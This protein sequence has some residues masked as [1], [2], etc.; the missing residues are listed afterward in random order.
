M[1]EHD[2]PPRSPEA[3]LAD[4]VATLRARYSPTKV[5][6]CRVCGGELSIQSV[7]GGEPTVWA[8]SDLEAD[9]AQ[10][11]HLRRKPGRTVADSHYSQSRWVDYRQGGDSVVMELLDLLAADAAPLADAERSSTATAGD[12]T[13]HFLTHITANQAQNLLDSFGGEA[14]TYALIRCGKGECGL[15]DDGSASPAGLYVYDMNCPE[16]GVIYL[17]DEDENSTPTRLVLVQQDSGVARIAAERQ[18]QMTAEGYTPD[19]DD[20][21][22][23]DELLLAA[24]TY[25]GTACNHD[26][27]EIEKRMFAAGIWPWDA[28]FFKPQN[29]VRDLERAGALVAAELD[30]MKRAE[31]TRG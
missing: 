16:E 8:C 15:E 1:N 12:P 23:Q 30:R 13:A 25:I 21:Y 31:T 9:P 5:P 18:R 20:R 19:G 4:I 28:R 7:G 26:D 6:A 11:G 2:A 24:A 29:R 27:G 10:P 17:G 14:T 22:T 3:R